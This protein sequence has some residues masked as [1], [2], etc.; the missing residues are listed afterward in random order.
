M[1]RLK[2]GGKLGYVRI[3]SVWI[4]SWLPGCFLHLD[5]LRESNPIYMRL[6]LPSISRSIAA[7]PLT[8]GVE[9]L[10]IRLRSSMAVLPRAC[11]LAASGSLSASRGSLVLDKKHGSK[12]AKERPIKQ[13]AL[14]IIR[15]EHVLRSPSPKMNGVYL[16]S[17]V[18]ILHF[19]TFLATESS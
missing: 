6:K 17:L 11:S 8:A 19:R 13:I 10:V 5:Q 1:K 12:I 14:L 18:F 15:A 9:K 2:R 16:L 7:M 4:V 3:A